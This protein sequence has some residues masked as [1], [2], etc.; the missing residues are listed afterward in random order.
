MSRVGGS[1]RPSHESL[2][3]SVHGHVHSRLFATF[4]NWCSRVFG[5]SVREFPESASTLRKHLWRVATVGSSQSRLAPP[6]ISTRTC[7]R[8]APVFQDTQTVL[9][10]TWEIWVDVDEGLV[11][12]HGGRFALGLRIMPPRHSPNPLTR[13][14]YSLR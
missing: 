8:R 13:E 1:P 2:G 4:R 6:V 11:D 12:E 7:P 14:A 3:E 10:S 5:I 9:P